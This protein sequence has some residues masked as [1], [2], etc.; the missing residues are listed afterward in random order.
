[1]WIVII[2]LPGL[3]PACATV[4]P[5]DRIRA[6]VRDGSFAKPGDTVHL[7]YGMSKQVREEFSQNAVVPVYRMDKGYYL[8]KSEVGKIKVTKEL[9]DHYIEAV[10]AEGEIRPSDIA[11]QAN[12]ECFII[13]PDPGKNRR[14][15]LYGL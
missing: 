10:V 9:G 11:M 7:F 8:N 6:E 2:S 14:C 13:L 12:S 5:D 15:P 4:Q 1:M 3:V